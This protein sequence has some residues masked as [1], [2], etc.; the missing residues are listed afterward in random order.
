MSDLLQKFKD[1]DI[2]LNENGQSVNAGSRFT[3]NLLLLTGDPLD[4]KT[5]VDTV[6]IDGKIVYEKKNDIRLQKL[7]TGKEPADAK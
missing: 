4:V 1:C 3:A 6:L 2:V 7:L 5:W